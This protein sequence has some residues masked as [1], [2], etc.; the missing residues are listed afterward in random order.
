MKDIVKTIL[1]KIAFVMCGIVV[2]FILIRIF[3]FPFVLCDDTMRPNFIKGEKLFMIRFFVPRVGDVVLYRGSPGGEDL[4][5]GRIV[6]TAGDLVEIKNGE[7][8]INEKPAQFSW[9]IV[10]K[11]KRLFPMSFSMRDNYP[12]VK[13]KRNE[14]FVLNDNIDKAMDSRYFGPITREK[15][16]GKFLLKSPF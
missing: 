5:V 15:I 8:L 10:R 3:L 6:A 7:I 9:Q 4:Y 12:A 11:D 1:F 16:K 14:Y 13:L 2:G